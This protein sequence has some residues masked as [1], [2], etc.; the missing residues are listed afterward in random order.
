MSAAKVEK[1]GAKEASRVAKEIYGAAFASASARFSEMRKAVIGDVELECPDAGFDERFHAAERAIFL[2]QSAGSFAERIWAKTNS[3]EQ[4][5]AALLS[6]FS[7]FPADVVR[8][9]L[10]AALIKKR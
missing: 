4:A 7:E 2:V 8:S 6:Q 3:Q 1:L 9:A 10:S 5:D